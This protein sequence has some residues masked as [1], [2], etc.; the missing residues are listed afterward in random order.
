[1]R[2]ML[3]LAIALPIIAWGG[4]QLYHEVWWV[5]N[6]SSSPFVF[7]G[8]FALLAILMFALH[9]WAH[10][11]VAVGVAAV[12]LM[13]AEPDQNRV[14]AHC[15]TPI[16]FGQFT[17]TNNPLTQAQLKQLLAAQL[18]MLVIQNISSQQDLESLQSLLV[19]YPYR[20]HSTPKSTGNSQWIMSR[21]MLSNVSEFPIGYGYQAV[22]FT[23]H[24]IP[25]K[26]ISVITAQLPYPFDDASWNLR[27]ALLR[28]V[29]SQVFI[30]EQDESLVIGNFSISATNSRFA[31][32]FPGFETAPVASWPTHLGR[33]PLPYFMMLSLDH[34]WLKSLQ[35]GR[36]ICM[37]S[38]Q[39]LFA[40]QLH[41]LVKTVIGFQ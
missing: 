30:D 41:R 1:M 22:K 28:G 17:L 10:F 12:Y 20:Y 33:L 2:W 3:W 9:Y 4:L 36:R 34:V 37:R 26:Q 27:N 14:L 39:P 23:W 29:E 24:P 11:V 5:E 38:S 40:D 15:A 32:L 19:Q 13:M 18:D 7:L 31:R 35:S 6:L 21:F 25:Q 8:Y 16:S